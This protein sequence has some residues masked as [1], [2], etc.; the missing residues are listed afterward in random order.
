MIVPMV[1]PV[2]RVVAV[3]L[4]LV[5]VGMVVVLPTAP[6]IA[7]PAVVAMVVLVR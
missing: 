4:A 7:M 2:C 3:V 6:A 5:L 1:F